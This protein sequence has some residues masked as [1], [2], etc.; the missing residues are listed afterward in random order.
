VHILVTGGAGFIGSHLCEALL[1]EG[2]GVICLDNYFTGSKEN[3]RHLTQHRSFEV[4][5]H[6]IIQYIDIEVEAIYNLACPA[7]PVHYQHD[8]IRTVH[9]NVLGVTNILELAR[10]TGARILQAST[11]EVYG[12]PTVHPQPESYWGNV[13][14]VGPRSC[15]DEGKRV[16]ETLL[17]DYHRQH[18][19]DIRIARIFNT[20][21]SR[22]APDDGRVVS[23]LIVQALRGEAM[24]VFG[25]GSHTRSF[26]YIDDMLRGLKALMDAKGATMPVNLG[27]P[28]ECSILELAELVRG[29]T[30]SS[31]EIRFEPLPVD[32]PIMRKPDISLAREVLKWEPAVSLEDGLRATVEYFDGAMSRGRVE[33]LTTKRRRDVA[34]VVGAG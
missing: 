27:N 17:M 26:C 25:D 33:F 9:A 1:A 8:A 31:S 29:L 11:S 14:P 5:R 34:R 19:V 20:Y 3:I 21:G 12:N 23:T 6:D 2:H 22:M 15:Y 16:A 18:G 24:T 28:H 32:D 13:N 7:S 10:R 4:I 30:G